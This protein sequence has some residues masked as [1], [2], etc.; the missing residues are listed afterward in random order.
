MFAASKRKVADVG[1]APDNEDVFEV[2]RQG[3]M[4]CRSIR[5]GFYG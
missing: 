5:V 4:R 2:S 1:P 3:L